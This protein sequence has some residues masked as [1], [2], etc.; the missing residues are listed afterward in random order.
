[1]A[2][3]Y[4]KLEK[5]DGT[6]C[7]YKKDRVTARWVREGFKHSKELEKLNEKEEYAAAIDARLRFTCDFFG[8]KDLT[9]DAIL[10]G[11]EGDKLGTTLDG[12]FNAIMGIRTGEEKKQKES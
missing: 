8:D 1:M 12:I 11:L 10:D 5:E 3:V 7:E 9:P 6:V 4:L 2:R